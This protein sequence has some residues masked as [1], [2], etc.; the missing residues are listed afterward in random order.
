MAIQIRQPR[1]IGPVVAPA[2]PPVVT[3]SPAW[4]GWQATAKRAADIVLSLIALVVFTPVMALVAIAIKLDSPGPIIFRQTRCGKDGCTFTFLK[5][6]GMVADAEARRAELDQHNEA[7]GPIFKMKDDPRV[8]RVGRFIR[9]T[10]LDELPQLWNVLR[11][12]MSLVGPRPPIPAE[13]LRYEPWQRDRLRVIPGITGLW[14]TS[15]RSGLSF[16]SMVHLD[17]EYI[18]TWSIWLDARILLSTVL[19]VLSTK[20]AY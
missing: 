13:V 14:Q 17:F 2:D 9:R 18:K 8:T 15:G 5:F 1:D 16:N 19:A 4:S 3:L 10:S 12:D 6:R 7:D 20:G 11:G